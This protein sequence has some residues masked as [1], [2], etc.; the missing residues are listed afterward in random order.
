MSVEQVLDP[1][2]IARQRNEA[3]LRGESVPGEPPVSSSPLLEDPAAAALP[4]TTF[5]QPTFTHEIGH[6]LSLA[7][8]GPTKLKCPKCDTVNLAKSDKC[9]NCG[10][11]LTEARKAKFA[12]MSADER[13]VMALNL[14]DDQRIELGMRV[15][16]NN[17]AYDE[18]KAKAAIAALGPGD[19]WSWDY[20]VSVQ[21]I[22][23]DDKDAYLLNGSYGAIEVGYDTEPTPQVFTEVDKLMAAVGAAVAAC[24]Q[25]RAAQ[26]ARAM[27]RDAIGYS[28]DNPD[29]E[30]AATLYGDELLNLAGN[31]KD[32]LVW[33][34]LCKTGTLALS[35]G[36]GQ[37]DVEKPLALTPDMFLATKA[38]YDEG[39]FEHVT[40]PETHGNGT[41]ENTGTVDQLDIIDKADAQKDVRLSAE[42]KK[43]I[44]A[45]PDGT[46][47]LLG[48]LNFTDPK[49]KEKVLNGS[50]INCS[51]GLKFGYRRKRDGKQFPI[52]LEHV[53]L[54][55]QPWID[56]LVPFGQSLTASQP[57]D[58]EQ[59]VPW[60]GVFVAPTDEQTAPDG[61]DGGVAGEDILP[62]E[63]VAGGMISQPSEE[64]MDPET[65]IPTPEVNEGGVQLEELLASQQA[66]IEATQREAE[67][68]RQQLALAQ[69][70][71]SSQGQQLHT[72][73]VEKRIRQLQGEGVP[74]AVL[75]KAHEI[76][77][78]DYG[79]SSEGGLNLS[80]TTGDG[81]DAKTLEFSS[82]TDVVEHLLLSVPRGEPVLTG[83]SG[84]V[85]ALHASQKQERTV[86]DRATEIERELHPE[87]FNDDGSRKAAEATN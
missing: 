31:A 13:P 28:Q 62:P 2:E 81:D 69:G 18:T 44:K 56:G 48:G 70:T 39:A 83:L 34:V 16:V 37:V 72:E 66:A 64:I 40:I 12:N 11:D 61:E 17:E 73:R 32:G 75:T 24:Q 26:K 5:A 43:M 29:Q 35:P 46:K 71:I 36:P 3:I 85:A 67:E 63:Q 14:S 22:S 59:E 23:A 55:N 9:K 33:K 76:M 42:A 87:R 15:S 74:P 19:R 68:L 7:E 52:A 58:Q 50:V 54:T 6:A 41:L 51:V 77:L 45:D 8:D 25:R 10:H 65:N 53:A 57:Y 82:A 86:D 80:V 27:M 78:A 1:N 20:D 60:D 30:H 38:A 49:A 4:G 79:A 21:K 84:E 47:Y